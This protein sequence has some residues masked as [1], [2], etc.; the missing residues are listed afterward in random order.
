M[1]PPK[2][3]K[4]MDIH[5][6]GIPHWGTDG[7]YLINVYPEQIPMGE[8]GHLWWRHTKYEWRKVVNIFNKKT[9]EHYRKVIDD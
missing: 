5:G 6:A 4:M 8:E 9:G 7:D 2:I 3:E 1:I